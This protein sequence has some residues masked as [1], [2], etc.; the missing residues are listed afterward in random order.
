[1]SMNADKWN[2]LLPLLDEAMALSEEQRPAFID[3]A[4]DGDTTLISELTKLINAASATEKEAFFDNFAKEVNPLYRE[5]QNL[6]LGKEFGQYVIKEMIGQGGMGDVYLAHDRTLQRSVALKFLP[7]HLLRHEEGRM[8]FLNEARAAASLD[9][10]NICTIFEISDLS[11]SP[12]IAMAYV[13]GQSLKE[14]LEKGPIPLTEVLRLAIQICEG[15]G[16]AHAHEV[17]HRDIKPANLMIN[18][19]GR[20]IIMDFGLAK[21]P[22]TE[23]LSKSG[24]TRGTVS[25]MSPEQ[26]KGHDVDPRSD[27]WSLGIVLYQLLTGYKPFKEKTEYE[28]IQ[29]IVKEEPRSIESLRPEVP[30][31]LRMLVYRLLSKKPRNRYFSA[32]DVLLELRSI[33]SSLR[34]RKEVTRTTKNLPSI[35]VLPFVNRSPDPENDYFCEG[36]AEDLINTLAHFSKLWV[37]ART[38]SFA[39]KNK[40]VDIKDIGRRLQVAHLLEGSVQKV[41]DKVRI[42]AQLIKVEDGYH[43]WSQKYDRILEDVFEVQD[44]IV[45]HIVEALKVK[46]LDDEQAEV[47]KHDT[48]NPEAYTTYLKARFHWNRRTQQHLEEAMI[49]SKQVIA[50]DP[51]YASA[52]SCLADSLILSGLYGY[53]SGSHLYPEAKMLAKKAIELDP[54]LAEAYTSL[55]AARIFH[56]WDWNGAE[57]ACRKAIAMNPNYP[58]GHSFFAG[59]VLAA[60]GRLPE[61]INEIS[62]AQHNDPLSFIIHTAAGVIHWQAGQYE[63]A[64]ELATNVIEMAPWFWLAHAVQGLVYEQWEAFDDAIAAFQKAN[65]LAGTKSST[66]GMGML[67]HAYAIAGKKNQ[68][69]DVLESLDNRAAESYVSPFDRAIIHTGLNNYDAAFEWLKKAVAERSSW[70]VLTNVDPRF[71]ELRQDSRFSEIKELMRM[72]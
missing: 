65:E 51:S 43:L 57:R 54:K 60:Q 55:G 44:E 34:L 56:E 68:S 41:G 6:R 24:T 64:F 18:N 47:A 17:I 25:Y 26:V 40:E 66:L 12:F 52:Y 29:A 19:R 61:A 2:R 33:D 59:F 37:A 35:A 71:A 13:D 70:I 4:C 48:H 30:K 15:L 5:P 8:R 38:S 23:D 72:E 39:F 9:H 21:L 67:G 46:L 1:M 22:G 10:P 16:V 53:K 45:K 49:Y 32:Q 62:I 20:L 28:L 11:E 27:L 14:L 3:K 50:L 7:E 63:K 58:T 42:V 31:A 36:L 69:L